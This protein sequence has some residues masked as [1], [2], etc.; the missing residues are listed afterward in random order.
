MERS[1]I[2]TKREKRTTPQNIQENRSRTTPHPVKKNS[3]GFKNLA[4]KNNKGDWE[5]IARS[6]NSAAS[7]N[8]V[9]SRV[10]QLEGKNPTKSEHP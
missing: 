9:W 1:I 8:Q 10:G 6:L 4:K 7:I 5:K 3:P 2:K